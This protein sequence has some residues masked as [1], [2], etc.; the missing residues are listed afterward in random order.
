M[1]LQNQTNKCNTIRMKMRHSNSLS[2]VKFIEAYEEVHE[3]NLGRG[4][5]GGP[6]SIKSKKK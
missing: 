2:I 3:R 4:R 6:L 1:K 5:G